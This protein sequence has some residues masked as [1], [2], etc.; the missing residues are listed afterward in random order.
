M[1]VFYSEAL[2]FAEDARQ[3]A[4]HLGAVGK[5]RAVHLDLAVGGDRYSDLF[6][7]CYLPLSFKDD[8]DLAR[9][10]ILLRYLKVERKILFDRLIGVD[11]C[12]PL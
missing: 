3:M 8:F 4:C 7:Q 1:L 12:E 10:F 6:I 11:L 5:D 2:H 9:Y